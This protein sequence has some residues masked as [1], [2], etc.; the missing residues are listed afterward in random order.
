MHFFQDYKTRPGLG[1]STL[2]SSLSPNGS[3]YYA[4]A[5]KWHLSVDL[6]PTEVHKI[7]LAQVERIKGN[8]ATVK[9]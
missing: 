3:D 4:A 2:A 6:S 7:G 1:V 9:L 5:L 8:M